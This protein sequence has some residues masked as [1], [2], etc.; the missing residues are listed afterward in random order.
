[1]KVFTDN[2]LTLQVVINNKQ[3]NM[4]YDRV[5][6]SL[7]LWREGMTHDQKV[8]HE[9]ISLDDCGIHDK[10]EDSGMTTM[11]IDTM[12]DGSYGG[13]TT[14]E[15]GVDISD[16]SIPLHWYREIIMQHRVNSRWKHNV[17]VNNYISKR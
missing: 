14:Y 5:C 8:W 1:M 15:R 17:E 12:S 6:D 4:E 3:Y 16:I 13:H 7:F 10:F 2:D 9:E 11:T